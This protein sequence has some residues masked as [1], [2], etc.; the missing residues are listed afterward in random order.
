MTGSPYDGVPTGEWR[1]LTQ[2]L[3]DKFPVNKEKLVE[4]VLE[5]WEDIFKTKIGRLGY[6]IGLEIL[7]QPQIMGFLLHELIPLNLATRYTDQWRRGQSSNELDALYIADDSFSFE[8]KTSSDP[9]NIF[10][11]RSYAYGSEKSKKRRE[12]YYLTVNFGKFTSLGGIPT[13]KLIK[14]GW[15]DAADWVGQKSQ[16][17][18]QA[19]LTTM[20]KTSKLII[21][22]ENLEK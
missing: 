5:S 2:E 11:N 21:L 10:G 20:A 19:S 3:I 6:Q 8:I 13:L 12:G 22:W 9:R 17:G 15:L 16:S 7:P 14:F 4:I 18:Q 1:A